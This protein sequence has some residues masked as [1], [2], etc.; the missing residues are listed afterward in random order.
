[1]LINFKNLLKK[2]R[3]RKMEYNLRFFKNKVEDNLKI[4][5]N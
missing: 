1:M 2:K 4:K 5:F 3:N